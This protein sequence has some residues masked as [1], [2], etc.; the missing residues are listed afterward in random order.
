MKPCILRL[1]AFVE[2]L[3]PEQAALL[4]SVGLVAGVF[5]IVG[6]PTA[7]CLLA[8]LGLRLNLAALQVLNN[9][10][11]PLQLALLL[12]L[13][14]AGAWLCGGSISG[15]GSVAGKLG[16]AA[17]HAVAGWTCVCIPLGAVLYFILVFAI[18]RRRPLWTNSVEIA[19]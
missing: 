18:R 1:Q 10:S 13:A 16:T 11:S 14:R 19:A 17:V 9:L 4:V 2:D 7:L 8:A 12:P 15:H 5:P 3:S 6:C